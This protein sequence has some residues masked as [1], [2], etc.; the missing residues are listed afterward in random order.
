VE[1]VLIKAKSE[2]KEFTV[3]VVDNAPFNE[4]QTLIKNLME[5]NIECIYTML[6]YVAYFLKKVN[7]IF[8]GASCML[9]NGNLVSRIGTAMVF[10]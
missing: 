8:I 5:K 7:K 9:N 3:I 1:Q 2:G 4:G 6:S 10:N